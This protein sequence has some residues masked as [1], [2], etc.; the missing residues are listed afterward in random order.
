M[1]FDIR[2]AELNWLGRQRLP[3]WGGHLERGE[4]VSDPQM[5]HWIADGMIEAVTEPR[6]GYVI[7]DKG[8]RWCDANPVSV[9]G[10]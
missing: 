1:T 7:T 5:R 4:P 3:M 9:E 6:P 8:R 2:K 10:A